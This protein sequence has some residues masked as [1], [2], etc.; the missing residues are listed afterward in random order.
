MLLY[1]IDIG[2]LWSK[3]IRMNKLEQIPDI[4]LSAEERKLKH[5]HE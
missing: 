3:F 4:N 2:I 5:D 1:L